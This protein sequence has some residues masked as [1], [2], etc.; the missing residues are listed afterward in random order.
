[1]GTPGQT[2]PNQKTTETSTLAKDIHWIHHA[3]LWSQVGLGVIGLLALW[4]YHGQLVEMRKATVATQ[5]AVD[6][7][8]RTL[9][10]TQ[11]S[12]ARQATLADQARKDANAA[13]EANRQDSGRALQATIDNFHQDQRAWV[14]PNGV[15]GVPTVGQ[16]FSITVRYINTGKT[17][18]L[19]LRYQTRS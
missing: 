19:H 11:S 8:S 3:T 14:G 4:I 18:A 7:A 10:E 6:V 15:T 12:N 5:G 9:T 2:D 1:M 16:P 13:S 17:P